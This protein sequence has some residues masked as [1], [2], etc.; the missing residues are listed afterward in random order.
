[1]TTSTLQQQYTTTHPFQRTRFTYA[2][3]SLMVFFGIGIAIPGAIMPFVADRLALTYGQTG[4]HFTA[5]AAGALLM[6]FYGERLTRRLGTRRVTW[7]AAALGGVALFGLVLGNHMAITM[8]ALFLYGIGIGGTAQFTTAAVSD[9]H[10]LHTSRVFTETSIMA[11]V[12][13]ILGP[14]IVS[15]L[16]GAGAGWQATAP[17]FL[18]VVI[19]LL[20]V[21]GRIHF[22]Q[23]S[24]VSQE[25]ADAPPVQLP[26]LFWV[27]GVILFLSVSIEWLLFYWSP[28]FLSTVVGFDRAT[29]A[30]LISVQAV[31]MLVG[32]VGGRRLVE[33]IPAG[34]LLILNLIWIL[35][36]FPVYL[37]SPYPLLNLVG[38]FGMGLGIANLFPLCLAGA[39]TAGGAHSGR[40]SG[41][42][43]IFGSSAM[44]IM[45]NLVGNLADYVN[46][47]PAMLTVGVLALVA[48]GVAVAAQRMTRAAK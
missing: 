42:V 33:I 2:A 27:F 30:G 14:L 38:L 6:G 34:K 5:N 46:I 13:V 16:S 36:W 8:A 22:P 20:S 35:G 47:R 45:P 4:M 40:A 21:N 37:F 31:A 10:R 17:V 12:G 25:R 23:Q 11:S 18:L 15:G 44:L 43:S 24:D 32:R 3:Y 7:A 19:T 9:A 1:M 39:M 28:D 48:I 41:R 26:P 29:A